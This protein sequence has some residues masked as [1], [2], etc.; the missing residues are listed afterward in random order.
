M[1]EPQ[2]VA[3]GAGG[4]IFV[5]DSGN[6]RVDVLSSAG[7]P[8]PDFGEGELEDPTGVAVDGS[9]VYVADSGNS[10]VARFSVTGAPLGSIEP[11]SPFSPA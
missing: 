4:Q 8:S 6:D 10:S 1:D 11:A 2:D 9:T 5:A 7:I 3:F